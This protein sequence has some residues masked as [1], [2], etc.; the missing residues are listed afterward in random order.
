MSNSDIVWVDIL[1]EDLTEEY[2]RASREYSGGNSIL[3]SRYSPGRSRI[4]L[5]YT[6]AT[7]PASLVAASYFPVVGDIGEY[8]RTNPEW[9]AGED[10][11]P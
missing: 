5:S 9:V 8:L 2:W 11:I 10:N 7:Y 4:L 3:D 1:L 6:A